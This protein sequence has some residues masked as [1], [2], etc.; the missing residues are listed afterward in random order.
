MANYLK[1]EVITAAD[2]ITT[3]DYHDQE[4]QLSNDALAIGTETLLFMSEIEDEIEGTV[5]ERKFFS[6]VRLFY[7]AV[8][9]KILTKFPLK[10]K[11]Q[12]T[13]HL[14]TP[15]IDQKVHVFLK[16]SFVFVIVL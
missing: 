10:D 8:V 14:L 6:S 7:E 15:V 3:I 11:R 5:I 1:P 16:V 2:D 9:T 4:K 12:V 13:Y